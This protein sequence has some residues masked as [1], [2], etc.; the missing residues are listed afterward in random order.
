MFQ[1]IKRVA[2]EGFVA[3]EKDLGEHRG[4]SRCI[5]VIQRTSEVLQGVSEGSRA[6][7][8]VLR[9]ASQSFRGDF[10]GSS[11]VSGGLGAFQAPLR[12]CRGF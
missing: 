5:R 10:E 3:F 2:L 7:A 11:G 1:V 12:D 9:D 4:A 6:V 8:E